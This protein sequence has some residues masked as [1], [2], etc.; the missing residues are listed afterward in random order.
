MDSRFETHLKALAADYREGGTE[1]TGRTPLE[2]L[3]NIFA[4]VLLQVGR[5]S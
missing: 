3:L 2:N 1:H 5:A 4:G